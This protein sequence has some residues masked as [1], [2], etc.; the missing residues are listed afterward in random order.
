MHFSGQRRSPGR[1]F[2]PT[3]GDLHAFC[4]SVKHR[5]DWRMS[6]PPKG[7]ILAMT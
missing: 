2:Q 5:N 6:C 3:P 1:W 7:S 4:C